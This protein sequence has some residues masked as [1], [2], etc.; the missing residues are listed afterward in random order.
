MLA[1]DFED[2]EIYSSRERSEFS[3][4]ISGVINDLDG[5]DGT[6]EVFVGRAY[7][8]EWIGYLKIVVHDRH[9]G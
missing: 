9:P 7:Q 4:R 5:S 6:D 2:L 3:R 1:L 8:A